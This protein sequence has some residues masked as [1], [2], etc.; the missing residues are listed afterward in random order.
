MIE[1][2]SLFI[3]ILLTFVFSLG[4]FYYSKKL[5]YRKKRVFILIAVAGIIVWVFLTRSGTLQTLLTFS[6]LNVFLLDS[7]IIYLG[8][9]VFTFAHSIIDNFRTK[10][11]LTI[12][13]WF[14]VF[15]SIVQ[16]ALFIVPDTIKNPSELSSDGT[17]FQSTSYTCA[18][19]SAVILLDKYGITSDEKEMTVLSYT[20]VLRGTSELATYFGI[21]E[22]LKSTQYTTHLKHLSLD[23]IKTL[24]MPMLIAIK[25]LP[26]VN[27]A[28]VISNYN[29]NIF[30]IID[31]LEGI[32][33]LSTNELKE[34]YVRLVIYIE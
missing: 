26:L 8:I 19:C 17:C 11:A 12:F 30:E 1:Y 7:Y 13:V 27:H 4:G 22:K 34:K 24:K 18:P 21:K 29:N 5:S 10:R 33:T 16:S 9:V 20:R 15:V 32:Y 2:V 25:H 3:N 31:P 6:R 23:E 14:V 28:V